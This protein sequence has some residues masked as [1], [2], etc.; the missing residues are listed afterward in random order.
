[1]AGKNRERSRKVGRPPKPLDEARRNR[2]TITLT[3]AEIEAIRAIAE[4]RGLPLG[5]VVHELVAR[6]LARRR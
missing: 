1:M 6:A 3:D 5:S 4:A 2:L